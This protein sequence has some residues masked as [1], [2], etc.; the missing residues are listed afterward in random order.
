MGHYNLLNGMLPLQYSALFALRQWCMDLM[1]F[2]TKN[3]N[4][5]ISWELHFCLITTK[6]IYHSQHP[7]SLSDSFSLDIIKTLSL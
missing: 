5:W 6:F 1:T 3:E 7:D 2:Q 4:V